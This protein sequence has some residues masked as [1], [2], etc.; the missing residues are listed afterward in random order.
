[1]NSL[2]TLL[3]AGFL[4]LCLAAC[5][6][7]TDL[8][9]KAGMGSNPQLPPPRE[10]LLPT[11]NIAP[12]IGWE[13]DAK[14]QAARG[15]AVN[16]FATDLD[17]PRQL[18]VLP[19]G[20]VLVAETNRPPKP[21]K[22]LRAWIMGMVMKRAGA[23]VPSANRITLLRDADGDGVAETKTAFLEDLFSPYGMA[24]VG[25][26]LYVANADALV[27]F[28]YT[29]GAT[30]ITTEPTKVADLPGGPINHHWTKNLIASPDGSK[31]YVA[32]GS[33][34]NVGENGMEN[35]ER[36]A[37]ILEID[38]ASGRDANLRVG[39]A[40]SG[41]HGLA[42]AERPALDLGQRARRNR[43]RPRARLYDLGSGWRLLRLAL[44]LLRPACR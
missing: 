29:E 11:V 10:T 34:S 43:Q 37:A 20:D 6:D 30:R 26:Q 25:D 13:D 39:P 41:R 36:R 22:G 19:N 3:I 5:G 16:A 35:E 23:G 42:A 18:Y 12:A 9:V 1:M 28:T 38:P 27:R 2:R 31:L 15:L 8:P 40:Q 7:E 14:P 17:H 32:V 44:Q 4:P 33:N 21:T 24:L